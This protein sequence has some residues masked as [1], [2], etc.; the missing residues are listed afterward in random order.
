[1]EAALGFCTRLAQ[2]RPSTRR[3]RHCVC[4]NLSLPTKQA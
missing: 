4:V 2:A 1:L 3:V